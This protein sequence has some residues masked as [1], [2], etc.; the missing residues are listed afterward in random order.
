MSP[1][2]H[3]NLKASEEKAV[4]RVSKVLHKSPRKQKPVVKKLAVKLFPG[5]AIFEKKNKTKKL[6]L[7]SKALK[8][9]IF[10]FY[11]SDKIF[12]WSQH[13]GQAYL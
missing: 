5:K 8:K 1:A 3:S 2:L 4:Q 12:S 7:L 11:C 13:E 6:S 10:D 9:N